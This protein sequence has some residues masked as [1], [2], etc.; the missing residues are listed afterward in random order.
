MTKDVCDSPMTFLSK[1]QIIKNYENQNLDASGGLLFLVKSHQS[2]TYILSAVPF[3]INTS[4]EP[5]ISN[6]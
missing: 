5:I 6:S 3:K 2:V 4:Q 1:K